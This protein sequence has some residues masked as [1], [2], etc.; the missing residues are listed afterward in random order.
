[1]DFHLPIH[2]LLRI[3]FKIV[4]DYK[5]SSFENIAPI[6][7]E[8]FSMFFC[9]FLLIFYHLIIYNVPEGDVEIEVGRTHLMYTLLLTR[10]FYS[11]LRWIALIFDLVTFKNMLPR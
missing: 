7:L 3:A 4:N 1:M 5:I 6:Y 11:R 10:R 2:I 9:W 8:Y